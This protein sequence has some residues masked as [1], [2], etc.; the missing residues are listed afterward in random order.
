MKWLIRVCQVLLVIMIP[1]VVLMTSVRILLTQMTV[2]IEYKLPNVT[3]DSYGF[4]LSER[5]AYAKL[6]VQYLTN[7]QGISFLGDQTFP[8]G[9]PLYNE[10]ELSHMQDVKNLVQKT[11][12]GWYLTGALVIL[13]GFVAWRIKKLS[14]YWIAIRD[15]GWA[16]L[17]LILTILLGVTINFDWL[18][19]AF[20]H[21]FFT[22]GTWLFFYSDTLIRLFPMEFWMNLFIA[23][24]FLAILFS[25]ILIWVGNKVYKR[26]S[27]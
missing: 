16:T 11:I 9:Q 6:A 24:G 20:H 3:A 4:K 26:K 13:A 19:T 23:L 8:N 1:F 12:Y 22:G 10:R 17:F 2:D 25:A 15:G 18:F 14:D 5:T 27:G 21:L 7:Y